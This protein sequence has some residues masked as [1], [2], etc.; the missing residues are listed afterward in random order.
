MCRSATENFD[1]S[2]TCPRIFLASRC[3]FLGE[4]VAGF[5]SSAKCELI[6]FPNSCFLAIFYDFPQFSLL[7]KSTMVQITPTFPEFGFAQELILRHSLGCKHRMYMN[8]GIR[9]FPKFQSITIINFPDLS[10]SQSLSSY[11]HQKPVIFPVLINLRG[12]PSNL[13]RGSY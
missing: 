4:L 6:L 3:Y 8:L 12:E 7:L 2:L 9:L 13:G 1:F 5:S 11:P 10:L